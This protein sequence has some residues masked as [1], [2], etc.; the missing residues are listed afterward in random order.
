MNSKKKGTRLANLIKKQDAFGHKITLNYQNEP[1]YRTVF[2][3]SV[4]I[5]LRLLLFSYFLANMVDV[6]NF[7]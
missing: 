5:I 3:G 7:A 2:G 4:T 6:I 1:N